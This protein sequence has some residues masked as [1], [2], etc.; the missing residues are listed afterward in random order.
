MRS[1]RT[2]AE[3]RHALYSAAARG[4]PSGSQSAAG[5]R[6]EALRRRDQGEAGR[7]DGAGRLEDRRRTWT[8]FSSPERT[9]LPRSL[10][11]Y[12]ARAADGG[13]GA[14]CVHASRFEDAV[15]WFVDRQLIAWT[16]DRRLLRRLAGRAV[17]R[18]R[19]ATLKRFSHFPEPGKML[20]GLRTGCTRG[21]ATDVCTPSTTSA[22]A[23]RLLC[24]PLYGRRRR[25][26]LTA[27]R[28]GTSDVD[29]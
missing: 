23:A 18:R 14:K 12:Q 29:A 19:R 5:S 16:P 6:L 24:R 25:C 9:S 26:A 4:C 13:D 28:L 10:R 15:L 11:P 20:V 17:V 22:A 7:A 8:Y 1:C 27:R 2:L 21:P 3:P